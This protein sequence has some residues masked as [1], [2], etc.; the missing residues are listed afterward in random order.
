VSKEIPQQYLDLLHGKVFAHLATVNADGTP[1][2]TPVW[3]DYDGRH[4][5][6]N[7]ARGR[8]KERNVRRDPQVALSA[9]DPA[10]PYRYIEVRGRVASLETKGADDQINALSRRYL[11]KEYPFC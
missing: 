1:Q 8:R 10:N 7:T 4:V 9:I 2:T 3:W 11:G 5:L 6:V